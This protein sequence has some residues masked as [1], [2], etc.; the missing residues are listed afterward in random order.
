MLG[1]VLER[2]HGGRIDLINKLMLT[3]TTILA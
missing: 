3:H 1:D 2:A